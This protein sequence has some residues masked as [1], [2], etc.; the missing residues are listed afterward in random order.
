MFWVYTR[1]PPS[2]C[3]HL[4]P[5]LDPRREKKKKKGKEMCHFFPWDVQG[6]GIVEA[7]SISS[8]F[9][10]Y[11]FLLKKGV[12]LCNDKTLEALHSS[13]AKF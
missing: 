9:I 3:T 8:V 4:K 6:C 7:A 5:S 10:S 11:S 13:L 12:L 2:L 1:P